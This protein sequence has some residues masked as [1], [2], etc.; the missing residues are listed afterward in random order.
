ML[1]HVL[2]VISAPR[3]GNL[4]VDNH[5]GKWYHM[6]WTNHVFGVKKT[7]IHSEKEDWIIQSSFY[8]HKARLMLGN[9]RVFFMGKINTEGTNYYKKDICL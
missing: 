7:Y 6:R 8:R 4:Q 3:T 5:V 1:F 2:I 9:C